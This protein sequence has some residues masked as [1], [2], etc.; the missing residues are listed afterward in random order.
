ME[1]PPEPDVD[2]VLATSELYTFLL[3][4][5]TTHHHHNH[6]NNKGDVDRMTDTTMED[7]VVP[8]SLD[9]SSSSSEERDWIIAYLESMPLAPCTGN[10][11]DAAHVLTSTNHASHSS[12]TATTQTTPPLVLLNSHLMES[13]HPT[14]N[15]TMIPMDTNESLGMSSSSTTVKEKGDD[16]SDVMNVNGSGSY[17]D[18]LFRYAAQT[19]FQH[20]LDHLS[21]LPWKRVLAQRRPLSASASAMAP[22]HRSSRRSVRSSANKDGTTRQ[23]TDHAELTLYHD[24][25]HDTYSLSITNHDSTKNVRPVLKFATAYG[26]KN[27]QLILQ[28]LTKEKTQTSVHSSSSLDANNKEEYH[29]IEVMACPS[30]CLNG[31]GQM[32]TP[33]KEGARETP[34][35]VRARV[36]ETQTILTNFIGHNSRSLLVAAANDNHEKHESFHPLYGTGALV[37]IPKPF[38]AKAQELLHTRFHVVPKL[39]LTTGATAGVALSDTKW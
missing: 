27:V 24:L 39:E 21:V 19:L 35:Q 16:T 30:G 23:Q 9:T 2:L 8:S 26:F 10:L 33:T 5:A 38:D 11:V 20:S 14:T 15:T 37:S 32:L 6:P 29:Y 25:D 28:K 12:E 1:E 7:A 3:Q 34:A 22:T 18:F 17:A 31:G 4:E 13:V 36:T